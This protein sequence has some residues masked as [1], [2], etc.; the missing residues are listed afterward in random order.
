[1]TQLPSTTSEYQH[2]RVYVTGS[3]GSA[4]L[5]QVYSLFA[6]SGY[7]VDIWYR[8]SLSDSEGIQPGSQR[9]PGDVDLLR[10]FSS[11]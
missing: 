4:R 8:S 10:S 2:I 3:K 9:Y 7:I 1:M 6:N 11:V 5:R